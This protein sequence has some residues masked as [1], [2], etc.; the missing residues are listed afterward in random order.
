M[1]TPEQLARQQ[2]DALLEAKR[3]DTLL[4]GV[5]EQSAPF[6]YANLACA[7]R[8]RHLQAAFATLA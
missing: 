7:Q 3:A 1:L 2:T 4:V 6:A 5:A 8:L